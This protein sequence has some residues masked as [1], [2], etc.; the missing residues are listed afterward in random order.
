M[1]PSITLPKLLLR[2]FNMIDFHQTKRT[3]V[4]SLQVLLLIICL[5]GA[6][7]SQ[8]NRG[9]F[10]MRWMEKPVHTEDMQDVPEDK[11]L[12][13]DKVGGYNEG[14]EGFPSVMQSLREGDVIAYRMTTKESSGDV[15]KGRLNSVGYRILDYGHLA[16]LTQVDGNETLKLLSSQSFKGPNTKE[17]VHT[18]KDHSFDVYRLNRWDKVDL[19]RFHDFVQKSQEKA[20][21]WIGYDFSGMFGV[22]NSNLRPS[23]AKA[24]G[25]DY[26]CSTIVAAAL[27]Y[28]GA[29]MKVSG[30]AGWLDL[31][32]PRQV[33]TSH[34]YLREVKIEGQKK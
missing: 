33:V 7:C 9:L 20:G 21:N 18:L 31:V 29:D 22:W 28:A 11:R 17:D 23:E 8:S 19:D 6:A 30:R 5:T 26:I 24:I 15:L 12:H 32:S 1:L 34:G 2:I 13:F 16:I 4:K 3:K 14:D 25:H 27:Y 10:V